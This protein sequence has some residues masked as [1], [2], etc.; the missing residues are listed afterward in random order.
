MPPR[1]V[2]AHPGR[3][4]S[5]STR[6]SPRLRGALPPP[7]HYALLT[8][9]YST[10]ATHHPGAP[11]TPVAHSPP[12]HPPHQITHARAPLDDDAAHRPSVPCTSRST[13]TGALPRS[14]PRYVYPL[15]LGPVPY[16]IV[17]NPPRPASPPRI[18]PRS[19]PL[20]TL[21][22][23]A[24]RLDQFDGGP[25]KNITDVLYTHREDGH[26]FV[27]LELWSSPGREKVRLITCNTA[28]Q[29]VLMAAASMAH[30]VQGHFADVSAVRRPLS[31]R[32]F[33]KSSSL[34][35]RASSW[36][37]RGRTIGSALRWICRPPGSRRITSASPSSLTRAAR[38]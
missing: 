31:R 25:Y 38:P 9:N 3:F 29:V 33:V 15:L 30:P 27:K 19:F 8:L 13:S 32:P 24:G 21:Y 11:H 37:P 10:T 35:T 7:L 22:R 28:S 2:K 1:S 26:E 16:R 6:G 34:R 12:V 36:A 14:H 18:A 20:S 23:I 4:G 17:A 5:P